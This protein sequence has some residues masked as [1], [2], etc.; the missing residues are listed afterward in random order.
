MSVQEQT[1]QSLEQDIQN[2]EAIIQQLESEIRNVE[3]TIECQVLKRVTI[4][5]F[6][7]SQIKGRN[8]NSSPETKS[9]LTTNAKTPE[10]LISNPRSSKTIWISPPQTIPTKHIN[11]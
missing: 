4:N 8:K 11:K 10:R 7:N 6:T 2:L 9:K 1:N 5:F 3:N